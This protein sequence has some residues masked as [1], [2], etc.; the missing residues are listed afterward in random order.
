MSNPTETTTGTE[1]DQAALDAAEL[2]AVTRKFGNPRTTIWLVL[3]AAIGGYIMMMGMG[4]ALQLRLS[5]IDEELATLV[6]SRAT[7]LSALLMLAVVPIVGAL[8]DRTLS[9]FG[10]RRP[11]I[12]GGYLV[13]LT[14]F[15]IIGTSTSSVVIIAAYIIGITSAQ[16]G[17]NA[18][19]VIPVEGVPG[20]MR[21]RIMGFMGLCG[22]L[23]MSA[24]AYIA[25]ALV[26]IST[27]LLMTVPPVLAIICALP[28]LVLYKDP[29]HGREEIPQGGTL[30]MFAHMFVNPVKHP[31]FGIVWLSRFLAGA[32]M[33]AFL[34][35]FVLY[36]IIGLHMSPAEA[37]AMAGRLSLMSAPVSIIVFIGSGWVSDKL[38]MLRPLVA[39]AAIIMAA[40]LIIAATSTTITGFTIAW[41]VFAVGQPMY[42]TVDLALCAKVLPNEADAGKDMAVFGLALNLGN[43]LVPA[44]APT[45]L[46]PASNNYPLLWGT[47]AAL[48]FV[49]ALLM[50]L[51]RGVK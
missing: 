23:A 49:G 51:V 22:A 20:N 44:I 18:Y 40:G 28:L 15:F 2:E 13:A 24:G 8:S 33:A 9:R 30:D 26:D 16:A 14:S 37:G 39:L 41:L 31:N 42:L 48:V 47:A 17:F 21:G 1:P 29:R 10:R 27:V 50:P 36:L 4:T 19:S 12:I 34:G 35:F 3:I 46:G 38:G 11:W 43:V 25:G 32:G 5:V 7:S 45:L 6:Y